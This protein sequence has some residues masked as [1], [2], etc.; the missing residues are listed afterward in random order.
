MQHRVSRRTSRAWWLLAAAF[1]A[2]L[3]IARADASAQTVPPGASAQQTIDCG[4]AVGERN[5]VARLRLPTI[6]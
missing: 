4:A 6:V 1:V 2:T 5:I 3:V